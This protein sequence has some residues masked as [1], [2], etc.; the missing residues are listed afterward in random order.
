MKTF[1]TFWVINNNMPFSCWE[2]VEC[3]TSGN[4]YLNSLLRYTLPMN[5]LYNDHQ[6]KSKFLIQA[7]HPVVVQCWSNFS[8]VCGQLLEDG[9]KN[10]YWNIRP[11]QV[12]M[13]YWLDKE[14]FFFPW[15]LKFKKTHLFSIMKWCFVCITNIHYT[16]TT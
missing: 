1:Q 16:M 8:H 5:H 10:L 6:L 15:A 11:L 4:N 2:W 12:A 14:S 3:T 9:T 7:W 13:A